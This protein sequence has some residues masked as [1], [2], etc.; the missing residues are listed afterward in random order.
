MAEHSFQPWFDGIQILNPPG[1]AGNDW[2]QAVCEVA[3]L[4]QFQFPENWI[5]SC[6][7]FLISAEHREGMALG[8]ICPSPL[9]QYL[10]FSGCSEIFSSLTFSSLLWSFF[11]LSATWREW[12]NF[13]AYQETILLPPPLQTKA[14]NKPQTAES[15][16]YHRFSLLNIW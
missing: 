15:S 1:V 8:A 13:L 10:L 5:W 7:E 6:D 2:S 9:G 14:I 11:D 3:G 16:F 12:A 4:F